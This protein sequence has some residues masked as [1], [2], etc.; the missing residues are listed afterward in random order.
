ME[1]LVIL[2]REIRAVTAALKEMS[3]TAAQTERERGTSSGMASAGTASTG[4]MGS[5]SGTPQDGPAVTTGGLKIAIQTL[6]GRT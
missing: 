2:E 3:A 4:G 6:Q 1:E 5:A